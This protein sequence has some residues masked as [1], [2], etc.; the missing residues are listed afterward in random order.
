MSF[1]DILKL[2]TDRTTRCSHC[3][4][5][6]CI[7]NY[8][9]LPQKLRKKLKPMKCHL[10]VHPRDLKQGCRAYIGS[11]VLKEG[12]KEYTVDVYDYDINTMTY[13]LTLGKRAE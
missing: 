11:Y 4:R 8:S 6:H 7:A 1:K 2:W 13:Y 5:P 10:P 3:G 9:L 12:D